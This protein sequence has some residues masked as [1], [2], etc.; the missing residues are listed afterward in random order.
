MSTL[1]A[2][3]RSMPVAFA[4]PCW[5]GRLTLAEDVAEDA[6]GVERVRV[7]DRLMRCIE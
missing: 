1:L 5:I 6:A 2:L 4:T 3:C 7:G